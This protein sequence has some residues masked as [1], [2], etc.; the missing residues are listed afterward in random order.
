MYTLTV[1]LLSTFYL[2]RVA[3][4]VPRP[5]VSLGPSLVNGLVDAAVGG[6]HHA[7]AQETVLMRNYI[8]FAFLL[9]FTRTE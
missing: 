6:A 4:S 8:F 7:A 9:E 5:R 1:T 3:H 2:T